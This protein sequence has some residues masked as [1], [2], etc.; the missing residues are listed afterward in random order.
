MRKDHQPL[1]VINV[2][3]PAEKVTM[4]TAKPIQPSR[5]SFGSARL[6]LTAAR[7]APTTSPIAMITCRIRKIEAGNFRGAG[8]QIRPT[9]EVDRHTEN[10]LRKKP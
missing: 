6:A 1:F 8:S 4:I 3:T 5:A 2:T 9:D 7:I 10:E